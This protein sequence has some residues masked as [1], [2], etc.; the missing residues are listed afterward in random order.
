M[1]SLVVADIGDFKTKYSGLFYE[2]G[3]E[4]VQ[5]ETVSK[6]LAENS[7]AFGYFVTGN[8]RDSHVPSS[9]GDLKGALKALN[10]S[11]WRKA[12]KATGVMELLP[13]K[14]REEWEN[15]F[16]KLDVPDFTV[17][18]VY[19][20]IEE[21]LLKRGSFFT[22]KVDGIFHAL[23]PEHITN[24]PN[25]F[26]TKLIINRVIDTSHHSPNFSTCRILDDL[27]DVL[28]TINNV[29]VDKSGSA[30]GSLNS[31][32]DTKSWGEWAQMS[33]GFYKI[34]IHKAGTAHIQIDEE[35]AVKLNRILSSKYPNAIPSKFRT[36]VKRFKKTELEKEFFTYQFLSTIR[37]KFRRNDKKVYS[38]S[39]DEKAILIRLGGKEIGKNEF[40]F[41]IWPLKA[42]NELL[43]AGFLYKTKSTQFYPTKEELAGEMVEMLDLTD[44]LSVLEPSAGQGGLVRAVEAA[45]KTY[46]SAIEI[47]PI[48]A[49]ILAT[50]SP[51]VN[52][53][54]EDFLDMSDSSKFDRIIMN[55][56]FSDGRAKL[57]VE[58]ALTVLSKDGVLVA[59]LPA[60]LKDHIFDEKLVHEYSEVKE[61]KFDGTSVRVVLVK[62]S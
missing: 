50:S 11:Y 33:G 61:D 32:V 6:I 28:Y 29:P 13:A 49:S 9:F 1:G 54:Q 58:K 37:D 55:P 21:L 46:I 53:T 10:T 2:Y 23:S 18:S 45:A 43:R 5:I 38:S 57:H 7:D 44:G 52:I 41:D 3:R 30:Y 4:R 15:R 62:I 60:S 34:K 22:D 36:T 47:D 26:R 24:T 20:T 25:G 14:Q 19:T 35:S 16:S 27:A 40:V 56:P 39:K 51:N 12:V 48:N 42:A 59:C 31:L 8:V 17:D